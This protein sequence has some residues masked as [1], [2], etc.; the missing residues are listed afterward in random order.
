[1]DTD[2]TTA[3]PTA[4]PAAAT[5]VAT[6]TTGTSPLPAKLALKPP[7]PPM[8]QSLATATTIPMATP[9]IELGRNFLPPPFY[10]SQKLLSLEIDIYSIIFNSYFHIFNITIFKLRG[11]GVLG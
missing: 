1:M 6:T 3:S 10:E 5:T 2:N 4:S 7:L 9:T 8:V 11:F